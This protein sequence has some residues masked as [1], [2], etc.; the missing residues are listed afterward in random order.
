MD[1]VMIEKIDEIHWKA[2]YISHSNRHEFDNMYNQKYGDIIKLVMV[3]CEP[4][5][6]PANY[7]DIELLEDNEE[8]IRFARFLTL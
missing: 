6:E 4:L 1:V 8:A 7:D 2:M 3:E 5:E